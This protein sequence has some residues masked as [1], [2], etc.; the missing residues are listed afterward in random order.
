MAPSFSECDRNSTRVCC[1]ANFIIPECYKWCEEKTCQNLL[2][3][4]NCDNTPCES[5][6]CVCAGDLY[7]NECGRC[8]TK[9]ECNTTCKRFLPLKCPDPNEQIYGCLDPTKA[10]VC[11][12][13]RRSMP[14]DL[15]FNPK[16]VQPGLCALTTCDCKN[17]Y[18]RNRCGQCVL[19]ADC[20]KKCCVSKSDPCSQPNEVR[21]TKYNK[22]RRALGRS[23]R[24]C[25]P[26]PH[27]RNDRR[28]KYSK[29]SSCVCED[30]FKRDHCGQ[31]LQPQEL[32]RKASCL[33]SNPC[34]LSNITGIEWIC[35]NE[36]NSRYCFN[37]WEI[38]VFKNKTCPTEC[39]YACQC[40]Q[41]ENLYFNGSAC[42]PPE[43]CQS[44]Q[45]SLFLKIFAEIVTPTN[46]AQISQ[47]YIDYLFELVSNLTTESTIPSP[48]KHH[49]CS[50]GN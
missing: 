10:K 32:L 22:N 4:T 31:C 13:L 35:Y 46:F 30:G 40:S 17:G 3:P 45:D 24:K 23:K 8:V 12:N 7:R 9:E 29:K 18:L 14:R 38:E 25:S 16:P 33:C 6:V 50:S 48:K 5:G 28:G 20:N 49:K 39:Y 15:F 42:V 19:A 21:V 44:Y 36:C 34:T 47:G 26:F 27:K 2:T 11:P 41:S 37:Y 43:Q 1:L